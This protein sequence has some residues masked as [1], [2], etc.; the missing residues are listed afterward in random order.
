M[1]SIAELAMQY[2][3]KT[4]FENATLNFDKGKRYG[5]VGANGTGKTTLLRLIS[6]EE[7]P[8]KGMISIPRNAD[9]GL[10]RQDHFRYENT[11]VSA[12][13]MQGKPL[14]WK[15]LQ[16]KEKLLHENKNDADTGHRLGHLEEVIAEENGYA[17]ESMA[18]E[19]LSG[20]GIGEGYHEGPMS[21]LSGGFKLRVLL[22]QLLFGAPK[23]LL[24]DEPT[25]HLDIVSIRWLENFLACEYTGT[26]IFISHDH[27]FLNAVATHIIDIDYQ[28]LRLYPG[29]YDRF[30][31]AKRLSETQKQKQIESLERK[32]AEMQAFVERFRY[33]ATKARQA[34][35]RVK[36]MEKIE[37]P[38][39]KRSSRIYPKLRFTQV[40]SS[41]RQVLSARNISKRFGNID[42]LADISLKV[43]R[44]EKVAVIGPNGI[45]KS[46][47]LKILLDRLPS[48]RGEHEWGYQTSISYFA[49][50]HHEEL[51]SEVSAYEWLYQSFPGETVGT[52][53]GMLGRVLLSG[54]EA[55]K[56]V[57]SLSGG[58]SARL[59]FAHIM[60]EKNNVLVLDEPTNHMDLEGVEALAEALQKYQGTVLVVSHD[61][62]FVSKVATHILALTPEGVRDFPGIYHEYLDNYG[63]D[64]L[65][66]DLSLKRTRNAKT[67]N[68]TPVHK[69]RKQLKRLIA[70][71]NKETRSL[72][73]LIAEK[74]QGIRQIN[75]TFGGNDFFRNADPREIERLQT[76]KSLLHDELNKNLQQWETVSHQLEEALARNSI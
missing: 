15:A 33:K 6:G 71:L 29:N 57:S 10:L 11:P 45:G 21:A 34:Q 76:S 9:L 64:Y 18:R 49:Q 36:Q 50:D 5:L 53:R 16:E 65:S 52:I 62:H 42:V 22:A 30:L 63:D 38:E 28:E 1:I 24:L 51:N 7:T 70:R 73:S 68:S 17:A 19:M 43:E 32:T 27:D 35:S 20:L 37:I 13:V 23:V 8:Y 69:N 39:I 25:N 47:L 44:G 12:V 3:Q 41:G 48:D 66:R 40:R 60:L 61:R 72:E 74:E 58:E 59:L 31:E 4:L 46:T 56:S 2:G 67:H 14:L 54:D 55:L 26:L 75:E